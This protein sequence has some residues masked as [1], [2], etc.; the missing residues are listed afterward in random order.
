MVERCI[1]FRNKMLMA[2][3]SE[4]KLEVKDE[5]GEVLTEG[6]AD[7]VGEDY[8]NIL[9]VIDW[10]FGRGA[11]P[12]ASENFQLATYCAGAMQKYRKSRAIGYIFQPRIGFI[13]R[14]EFRSEEAIVSNIKTIRN[15]AS[16]EKLILN[17]REEACKYCRAKSKC[18]AFA[19]K[20][21]A[22]TTAPD[23]DLSSEENLVRLYDASKIAEKY[24]REIK[25]A[26]ES[27]IQEHGACGRY[28]LKERAGTR[29]CTDILETWKR[30][31]EYV[32]EQEFNAVTSVSAGKLIDCLVTKEIAAAQAKGVKL[33]K[34]QAKKD[35]EEL[36]D[37]LLVRGKTTTTIAE[38]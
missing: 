9:T 30:V 7:V 27:Y 35:A 23:Y 13:S 31:G 24:I 12:E 25:S 34:I 38:S 8:Q 15:M 14:H 18:P 32:T 22:L 17:A 33:T 19:S 21:A 20:F 4:V 29:E 16:G 2:Y 6:T 11:V 1:Q 10:K 37:G 36:L 28:I 26:V 5:N 3:D